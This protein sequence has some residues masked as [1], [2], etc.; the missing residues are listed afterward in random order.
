[1]KLQK[2]VYM[3]FLFIST[4]L[5]QNKMIYTIRGIVIDGKSFE[6]LSS[7]NIYCNDKYCTTTNLEGHFNFETAIKTPTLKIKGLG[8]NTAF[9]EIKFTDNI[10]DEVVIYLEPKPIE[11][12]SVTISGEKRKILNKNTYD[13][14]NGDIKRI[15]VFLEAD[16]IRILQTLPG[17]T[18]SSDINS[19]VY[20]RG[21]NFDETGI[22]IDN[23]PI[24]NAYHFGGVYGALNPDIIKKERIYSSN[25]TA[26]KENFLSGIIDLETKNGNRDKL[27][28][29]F[30]LGLVSSK[31]YLEGPLLGGSF[32]LSVRR[33]YHDLVSKIFDS[34]Y[35]FPYYF[36]DLYGKY[37]VPLGKKNVVSFSVFYARDN[38]D[39]YNGS[40]REVI[41]DNEP[42]HWKTAFARLSHSFFFN[43]NITLENSLSYSLSNQGADAASKYY[44]RTD[45]IFIANKFSH[46]ILK[47][48]LQLN[49][50]GLQNKI[51]FSWNNYNS[52]YQWN[53]PLQEI[54]YFETVKTS[55]M[56][57]DFSGNKY[58]KTA[59]KKVYKF[60]LVSK[61][62][63]SKKI[64][65]IGGLNLVKENYIDEL[66][67]NPTLNIN[68][69]VSE[70]FRIKLAAGRY[71]QPVYTKRDQIKNSF[72]APFSIYFLPKSI[73]YIPR[74][75]HYTAGLD[76]SDLPY[77]TDLLIEFYYKSR[78]NIPTAIENKKSIKYYDGYAYG[79]DFLLSRKSGNLTGWLGYSFL[80]SIKSN[81]IYKFYAGYDRTH[82]VKILL[83]YKL[84]DTWSISSFWCY[85]S[86]LPYT[87]ISGKYLTEKHINSIDINPN[88]LIKSEKQWE[89][90]N[91]KQNS[92][93]FSPNHRLDIGITGKF[94]WFNKI[95]VKPYLQ[96]LNIYHSKNPYQ[97]LPAHTDTDV[98]AGEQRGSHILP[99]VGVILEF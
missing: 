98:R 59:N 85:N 26:D 71:S 27:K 23:V 35:R 67:I 20:V 89:L 54:D 60:Y 93:R 57:F 3:V 53:V 13:F 61:L 31:L 78:S 70:K 47:S 34:N 80:R 19:Q 99:T 58:S 14:S 37:S 49:Y 24:Y 39:I 69:Y 83:N 56:F 30:S 66:L 84:S 46:T 16:A 17:I 7:I 33:S 51:G 90:L 76:L 94:I 92:K 8:F 12:E 32:I 36:Y 29:I 2:L 65:L 82:S 6:R 11:M 74:S 44:H 4:I 79:V 5:C 81:D 96:I 15:P 91:G 63:V 9:I 41:Y 68:Y 25:Y 38:V 21:G 86:G 50:Q 22:L 62:D 55:N 97:Y 43:K 95:V 88:N 52:D 28:G 18:T 48:E 64:Q 1:M 10:T 77:K 75:N 87:P 73:Q 45:S 40:S 42:L 72:L